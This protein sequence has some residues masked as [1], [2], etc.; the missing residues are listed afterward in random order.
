MS[1]F[2]LNNNIY[3]ASEKEKILYDYPSITIQKSEIRGPHNI[4][5]QNYF[6]IPYI[7]QTSTPNIEYTS[8]NDTTPQKFNVKNI[9]Y[10]GLLH[11]NIQGLTTGRDSD[12]NIIG[13]LVI[14][15]TSISNSIKLYS[16]YLLKKYNPGQTQMGSDIDTTIELMDTDVINTPIIMNSAITKA[17][18]CIVYNDGANKIIMVNTSPI[19]IVDNTALVI[20]NSATNSGYDTTTRLFSI[21]APTMYK[22]I[23]GINI[24]MRKEEDIYIDCQPTGVSDKEVSTYNIPLNSET[25]KEKQQLDFMKTTVNFVIFIIGLIAASYGVPILYKTIVINK[26]IDYFGQAKNSSDDSKEKGYIRIKTVDI[27]IFIFIATLILSIFGYGKANGDYIS[28][29]VCLFL[30]IF[31]ILS[32]VLIT[33]KKQDEKFMTFERKT[34][35]YPIETDD[36]D[37]KQDLFTTIF[38][39]V[40]IADISKFVGE[41]FDLI[42]KNISTIFGVEIVYLIIMLSLGLTGQFSPNKITNQNLALMFGLQGGIILMFLILLLS[43]LLEKNNRASPE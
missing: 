14:E 20:Y 35:S 13:E 25:S 7:N 31:Y 39:Y 42:W 23:N 5:T 4:S 29:M 17:D 19:M 32:A 12:P 38:K 3:T 16:C 37:E 40:S 21:N 41:T 34:L 28:F 26:I 6:S 18:K 9:Y 27:F 1:V 2:E 15:H 10:Y 24:T 11:N 36:S 30:T 33:V 43:V 22:L 8:I